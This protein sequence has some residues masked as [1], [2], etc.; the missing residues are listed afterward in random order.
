MSSIRLLRT[1]VAVATEGSFAA[2]AQRVALTQAA[3]GLQM[4]ALEAE[5]RRPLFERRGK[6]VVINQAGRELLPLVRQQIALYEQMLAFQHPESVAGT[7]HIGVVVASL[8]PLVRA[9]LALKERH[10]NLDLHAVA[11]HTGDLIPRVESGEFDAAIIVRDPGQDLRALEVTELYSEPI[12]ALASRSVEETSVKAMLQKYPFIR[13]H[14]GDR[15]GQLVDGILRRLKVQ[16]RDF[17]ELNSIDAIVGVI[18][19]GVG[20]TLLPHLRESRWHEDPALRI[21][22]VGRAKETRGI[23]LVQRRASAKAPLIDAVVREFQ[24]TV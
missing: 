18:R 14:R 2:A 16:P 3:V 15:T 20:V 10:P 13:F 12:V 21:F 8:G 23:A 19:S 9:T 5:M 4:R 24:R 1:F 7:V 11:S 6:T 17:L 22:K